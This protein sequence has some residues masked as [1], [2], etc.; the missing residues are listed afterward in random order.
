MNT[1]LDEFSLIYP[2]RGTIRCTLCSYEDARSFRAC[3][4]VMPAVAG[5]DIAC[6]GR[7]KRRRARFSLRSF[8]R[9][10]IH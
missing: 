4:F 7:P 2:R 3:L 10:A 6:A 8:R 5:P 9:R 1:N